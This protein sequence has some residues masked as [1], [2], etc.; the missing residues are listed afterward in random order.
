V[1]TN[2]HERELLPSGLGTLI[3]RLFRRRKA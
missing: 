2:T 1:L 3:R